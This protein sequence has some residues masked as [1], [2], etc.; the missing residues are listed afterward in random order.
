[1]Q[2]VLFSSAP[3]AT[4]GVAAETGSGSAFG[5][6]RDA[7]DGVLATPVNGA[8]VGEELV[9]DTAEARACLGVVDGDR[10]VRAV[11]ARHHERE[12]G[13]GEKEVV[14]RGVGEH[15]AELGRAGCDRRGNR[16]AGAPGQQH[17]RTLAR[18]QERGRRRRELDERLGRRRHQGERLVLAVLAAP[19]P[20]HRLLVGRVAGE[21]VAAEA[22][23]GEDRA[24]PEE[25]HGLVERQRKP[26]PADRTGD[27][28]GMEPTVGRILVLATAVGAQRK[29]R[30]RRV[31]PVVGARTGCS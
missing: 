18:A 9:G 23:H 4:I 3:T 1:M 10:L 19:E 2:N 7:D 15:H 26:R 25:R 17:D 24:A 14:E 27:R 16:S 6:E 21:V 20:R 5:M 29:A 13:V 8:V 31:G 22:L 28:L 11:P 30:H 12:L